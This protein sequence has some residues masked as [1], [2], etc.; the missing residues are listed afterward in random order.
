MK[1]LF[2]KKN[3]MEH[4]DLENKFIKWL[5]KWYKRSLIGSLIVLL[6][7]MILSTYFKY[8]EDYV[9][10]FIGGAFLG[11]MLN[12]LAFQKIWIAKYKQGEIK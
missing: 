8:S 1:W 10:L 6:L 9:V 7:M 5:P 12:H 3:A 4:Q 11:V 2:N